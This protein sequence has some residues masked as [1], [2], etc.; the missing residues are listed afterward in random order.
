MSEGASRSS[1]TC[2][3]A[4][5]NWCEIL[6][7]SAA[8]GGDLDEVQRILATYGVWVRA[9]TEAH[10]I[11]TAKLRPLTRHR[12]LGLGDRACI[13]HGRLTGQPVLT[14]E[15]KWVGLDL[16]VEIVLFR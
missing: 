3:G 4:I 10:A 11:E 16:G 2:A 7:K 15:T 9:F 6:T 5:V 1:R 12:G 13:A 8:E 14:G